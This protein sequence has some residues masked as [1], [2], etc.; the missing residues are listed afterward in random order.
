MSE[1]CRLAFQAALELVEEKCGVKVGGMVARFD[2]LKAA[3]RVPP[4]VEE[5]ASSNPEL[6]RE[7]R[8]E[9]IAGSRW[10]Q[11][12]AE[13]LCRLVTG[14]AKPECVSRMSKTLAERVV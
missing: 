8:V 5:I 9:S 14:E 13:G 4:E 6:T 12:W 2:E 1:D 3:V 10:A 7:Q 11:G